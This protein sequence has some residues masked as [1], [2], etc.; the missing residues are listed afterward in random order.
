MTGTNATP[1]EG[2][3]ALAPASPRTNQTL[4][5]SPAGFT[6]PDGEALT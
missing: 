2:T 6:E 1:V 4:T 5:A 3:V